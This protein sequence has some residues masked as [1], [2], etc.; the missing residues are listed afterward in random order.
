MN[1]VAMPRRLLCTSAMLAGMT[2]G[3]AGYSPAAP[4]TPLATVSGLSEVQRPIANAIDIVCPTLRPTLHIDPVANGT[5]QE[6]FFYS[7]TSVV[8]TAA[9]LNGVPSNNFDRKLTP[10]QFGRLLQDIGPNQMNGQNGGTAT[11]STSSLI[12][13][14]LFDLRAGAR[15][16]SIGVNGV[17]A[18]AVADAGKAGEA[19]VRATGG[20]ASADS[21]LDG[22]LSGFVKIGGNWGKVD[23]TTLQDAY[24]YDAFSILAG[25]DYR[26]TNAFVVG[27]AVSYEDTRSRFDN[28][29]GHVDATTWSVAGYGTY[30]S[31]PWYV[32]GFMSYGNVDY[33]T[34]RTVFMPSNNPGQPP[35]LGSATASPRGDQWSLALGTGYNYNMTGYTVTPFGRLGYIHVRN[36]AFS[37][38]EPVTGMGLSVDTRTLESL[39]LA[40][41]GTI[42]TTM[43]S[44]MGVFIPYL[45]AQWVHEFKND[46]PSIVA[47][48]VNDPNGLQFFIPTENPTR[49]Y[50]VFI[51]GSSATFANGLS[52]FVQVGAAAGL[53]DA[54]NYSVTAGL[55]KEF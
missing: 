12:A 7:C 25:A 44:S 5:I 39:Q 14:R 49:D 52:G 54:T 21:P 22:R 36:K 11:R 53:K 45:T 41:G 1:N 43:N 20:G 55:R 2:L 4:A 8:Q 33:D 3:L 30:T 6:R 31:G 35:L 37:E 51:V 34:T 48:F 19:G 38:S 24:K 29:L 18:P 32:D 42:S 46:N 16:V 13:A 26:V 10:E 9:G 40:L 23:E 47:K 17:D 28:S 15:G 27:G 50:A